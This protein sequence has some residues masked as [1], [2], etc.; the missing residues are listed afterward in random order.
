MKNILLTSYYSDAPLEILLSEIGSEFNL[1][2]PLFE[3]DN[4]TIFNN[5]AYAD[6]VI[7][8]GR[9]KIDAAFL[10][11]ASNLKMIQRTG[12]GLD[13]LDLDGIRE[14]NIPLY[15]NAGI[16]AE[17]VSELALLLILSSLRRLTL[18][19]KNVKSGVWNKQGQGIKTHE[20]NNKTIGIVGVGNIGKRL[21]SMLA[22]FDST[23]LYF[24]LRRLPLAEEEKYRLHYASLN[25]LFSQSDIIS[26][27]C[28]LNPQT[29]NIINKES[30]S[31]MKDG[32]ILVN[33]ARGGLINTTDLISALKCGKFSFAGLDVYDQEPVC[34]E[35]L[36]ALEN[37]IT[38]P[39]IGGITYESFSAMMHG[40]IQN[41]REFDKGN[42]EAIQ[43]Y[44]YE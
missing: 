1:I 35:E 4:K 12:V 13:S 2:R 29:A 33:T 41:I 32:V 17:S 11:K 31:L 3:G 22:P 5:V 30:I 43:K 19:D 10:A 20:L 38:T 44:R 9:F 39:H 24:D 18:I 27:H 37:V 26:L 8:S 7:A 16:N 34:N 42:L 21:A 23:L 36:L 15:V 40:A 25:E 28:P 6:Y 14:R